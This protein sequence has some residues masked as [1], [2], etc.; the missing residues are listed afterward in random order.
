[1]DV[2]SVCLIFGGKEFQTWVAAQEKECK[3]ESFGPDTG[4]P[5]DSHDSRGAE[6][7]GWGV[8]RMSERYK[9]T[10]LQKKDDTK[11]TTKI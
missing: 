10:V 6:F 1:M 8:N 2:E 9:G 4:D 3:S 7:P 11:E 5:E